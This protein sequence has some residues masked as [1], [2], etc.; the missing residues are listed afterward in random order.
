MLIFPNIP[1]TEQIHQVLLRG[2]TFIAIFTSCVG[3]VGIEIYTI[4]D[5]ARGIQ[6]LS[7]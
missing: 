4:L 6:Y 2:Y 1:Q 3:A 7:M 5:P